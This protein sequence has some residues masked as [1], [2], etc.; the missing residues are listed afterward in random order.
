MV[1]HIEV[2]SVPRTGV[3]AGRIVSWLSALFLLL[4][5]VAKLITYVPAERPSMLRFFRR[6]G[7][8]PF[9]RTTERRTFFRRYVS[10]LPFEES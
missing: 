7:F 3:W 5:G 10:F 2:A 4:D 6:A 8:E 9:C 1:S